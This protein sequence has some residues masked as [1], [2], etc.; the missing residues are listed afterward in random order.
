MKKIGTPG[1]GDVFIVLSLSRIRSKGFSPVPLL[2]DPSFTPW[3]S[4]SFPN[5]RCKQP[6]FY[7]GSQI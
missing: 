5:A 4:S 7:F 1:F 3:M 6:F 2:C